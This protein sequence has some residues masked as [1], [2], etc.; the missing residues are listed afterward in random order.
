MH[1]ALASSKALWDQL[2]SLGY[3]NASRYTLDRQSVQISQL[4]L[5]MQ[6]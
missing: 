2:S 5:S 1:H 6:Q 4:L 3:V